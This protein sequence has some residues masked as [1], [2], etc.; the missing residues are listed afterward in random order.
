MPEGEENSALRGR[1]P[2]PREDALKGRVGDL[3]NLAGGGGDAVGVACATADNP[4]NPVIGIDEK[5]LALLVGGCDVVVGEVVA[6]QLGTLGHAEGL[7]TVALAPMPEAKGEPDGVGVEEGRGGC[8]RLEIG[9]Q[10]VD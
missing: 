6:D 3:K 8:K 1:V 5:E 10:L 4:E 7:E 9:R 2:L